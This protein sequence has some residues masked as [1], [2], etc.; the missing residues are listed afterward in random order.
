[1]RPANFFA[2]DYHDARARFL[3]ACRDTGAQVESHRCPASGP[4]G[5]APASTRIAADPINANA[6]GSVLM[7]P[8]EKDRNSTVIRANIKTVASSRLA[9]RS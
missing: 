8:S 2:A 6:L 3:A 1:M 7:R 4:D 5:E 9:P